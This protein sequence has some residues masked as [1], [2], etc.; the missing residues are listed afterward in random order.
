MIC[1]VYV[2]LIFDAINILQ[3]QLRQ[4]KN[5]SNINFFMIYLFLG[6]LINFL[7]D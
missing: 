5:Y 7:W 6:Y 1:F 4:I 2:L 3:Q